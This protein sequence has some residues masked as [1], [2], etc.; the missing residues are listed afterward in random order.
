MRRS[1]KPQPQTALPSRRESTAPASALLEQRRAQ[2][3]PDRVADPVAA[4]AIAEA[5]TKA[6][7]A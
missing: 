3:L 7:A 2:G 4:R 1:P 5:L 6:V